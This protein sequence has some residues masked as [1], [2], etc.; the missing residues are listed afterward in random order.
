MEI[1]AEYSFNDGHDVIQGWFLAEYNEVCSAIREVDAE[2]A[3]VKKSREVTMPGRLLYSPVALNKAILS[4][5]LYKQGWQKPTLRYQ[6]QIPEIDQSYQGYIEGDGEKNGLGL[7]VQFGKYAFLGWDI[8]GKM[9]VFAM[10]DYFQAAIEIVPMASF[11]RRKQMSS[12]IGCYEQIKAM[13]LFGNQLTPL[14]SGHTVGSRGGRRR[15]AGRLRRCAPA[16]P[17]APAGGATG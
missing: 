13:A 15:D 10:R 8:L 16:S 5:R 7:E 2:A 3:R 4:E 17:N 12:G 11:S 6:T 1:I 14:V 9:P